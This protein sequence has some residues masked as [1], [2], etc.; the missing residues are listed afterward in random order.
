MNPYLA[1]ALIADSLS[2]RLS[3]PLNIRETFVV[4]GLAGYTY[5]RSITSNQ[6]FVNAHRLYDLFT[7]GASVSYR[8]EAVPVYM[9]LDY[10]AVTQRG[11]VQDGVY[12]PSSLRRLLTFGFGGGETDNIRAR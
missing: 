8:F 5:A 7:L 10:L 1:S 2:L 9:S 11:S 6:H 12:S 3:L 4:N